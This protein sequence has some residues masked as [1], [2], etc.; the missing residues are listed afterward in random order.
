M[1]LEAVLLANQAGIAP[2]G[3]LDVQGAAWENFDSDIF[4]V[5]VTG[6]VVGVVAL[7][8]AELAEI[9]SVRVRVRAPSGML[10][11]FEASTIINTNRPP[12][13]SGVPTRIP[14]LVPLSVTFTEPTIATVEVFGNGD[15]L[16]ASVPFAVRSRIPD[17]P[18]Q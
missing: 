9:P 8:T 2:N 13:E 11:T 7:D 10:G 6:G 14:F 18:E 16:L 3:L 1:K 5:T 4:P 17:S 15:V 12:A